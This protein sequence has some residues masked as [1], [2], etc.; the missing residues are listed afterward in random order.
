MTR[1]V[2]VPPASPSTNTGLTTIFKTKKKKM[3]HL[4]EYIAV[5]RKCVW[6]AFFHGLIFFNLDKLLYSEKC[7][8]FKRCIYEI[9]WLISFFKPKQT[10]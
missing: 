3:S 8:A 1:A 4:K 7:K 9:S 10:G 2:Q 5:L 6:D